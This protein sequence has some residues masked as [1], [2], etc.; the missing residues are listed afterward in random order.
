MN[1]SQLGGIAIGILLGFGGGWYAHQ[2][3]DTVAARVNG[4][5]IRSSAL[6]QEL[7]KRFGNDVL[8]DL[9]NQKLIAQEAAKQKIV[10]PDSAITA[11]LEQLKQKPNVQP[12]LKSGQV[13]E[14]DLR[15]NLTTLLPWDLLTEKLI[16]EDDEKEFL[17]QH[18]EELESLELQ[19]MIFADETS[20]KSAAPTAEQWSK[21]SVQELHRSQLSPHWAEA[22]FKLRKG[23]VSP[24]LAGPDGIHLFRVGE[25]RFEYKNLKDLVREQLVAQK[26]GEVLEDIRHR[27]KLEIL[28]P[29]KLRSEDG[30]AVESPNSGSSKSP[31]HPASS[32][33][34]S[35][36]QVDSD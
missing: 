34:P 9:V 15:R 20:F 28:P 5:E 36:P 32:G 23:E 8:R 6:Q 18:R 3:T 29:Y 22:L 1:G 26:R 33:S 35:K 17:L 25:H 16:K 7:S 24:P 11:K 13:T 31:N 4:D 19:E 2:P 12:L 27:A 30:G 10:V 21:I 14:E